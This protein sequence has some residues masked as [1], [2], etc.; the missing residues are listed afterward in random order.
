ME[1]NYFERCVYDSVGDKSLSYGI[2]KKFGWKIIRAQ[3]GF[4]ISIGWTV[5]VVAT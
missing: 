3:M 1:K 2:A 5:T 4:N